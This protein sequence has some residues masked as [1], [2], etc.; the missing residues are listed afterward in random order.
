V[1]CLP[2]VLPFP[3]RLISVAGCVHCS[4]LDSSF[5]F[6]FTE[7]SLLCS[8]C[9]PLFQYLNQRSR[10][11]QRSLDQSKCLLQDSQL[12]A[13]HQQ[14]DKYQGPTCLMSTMWL[15]KIRR[16]P[17]YN[18]PVILPGCNTVVHV[19]GATPAFTSPMPTVTVTIPAPSIAPGPSRCL[20]GGLLGLL[21]PQEKVPLPLMISISR[22]LMTC[23]SL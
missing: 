5:L 11:G 15:P 21:G 20:C 18:L 22:R 1:S 8:R 16:P 7:F 14:P 3:I 23:M 17:A 19:P 9:R 6:F 13:F 12:P 4:Y 10:E 2:V